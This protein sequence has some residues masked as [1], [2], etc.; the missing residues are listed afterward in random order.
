MSSTSLKPRILV[1]EDESAIRIGVCDLLA[2]HGY[3]PIPAADGEEGLRI[4]RCEHFD[5]ALLDVMLPGLSGFDLCATLRERSPYLPILMLT[6]KGSED[7]V[8]T[9][10]E[11]GADDY[12]IKPFSTRELPVRIQALLR[13]SGLLR[14][15]AGPF[16]FGPWT[17][18]ADRLHAEQE[19]ILVDLTPRELRLLALLHRERG[20]IISRRLLL[21]EVWDMPNPDGIET[22]TVDVHIAKLRKKIGPQLIETVRGA[23]YRYN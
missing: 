10:F 12:I 15:P 9:G 4:S 8:I 2:F 3:H 20:R 6:A 11:R 23:G 14:N 7:D 19:Q 18:H 5:L 13:R 16:T 1:V 21:A 22:R 17:V